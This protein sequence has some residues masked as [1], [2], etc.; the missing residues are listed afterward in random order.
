MANI[1]R[2]IPTGITDI[3]D[4]NIKTPPHEII[5]KF[6]YDNWNNTLLNKNTIKFGYKIR[7]NVLSTAKNALKC[8]Y[9]GGETTSLETN[10]TL[11]KEIT[12]VG[13]ILEARHINNFKDDVPPDLITMRLILK[14]VI[15]G[16]RLALNNK[17]ILMMT[18]QDNNEIT[19]DESTNYIYKLKVRIR[20]LQHFEKK[21]IDEATQ[22]PPP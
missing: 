12:K 13:V 9:E 17:G 11:T 10:D 18:F 7:Q 2:F 14:D 21:I 4:V 16:N 22:V 15:N 20:C 3:N 6:I 8:Y 1:V 5:E 19:Q